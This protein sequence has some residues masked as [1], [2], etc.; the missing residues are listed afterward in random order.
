MFS[1]SRTV[2]L[3]L[4]WKLSNC[5]GTNELLLE[6]DQNKAATDRSS[7]GRFLLFRSSDPRTSYDLWILPMVGDKKPFPWTVK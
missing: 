5:A 7:D 2:V 6:S 3:S 4:Y 1:S